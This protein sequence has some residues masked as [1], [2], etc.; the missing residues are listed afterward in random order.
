MGPAALAGGPRPILASVRVYDRVLYRAAAP[1]WRIGGI[2]DVAAQPTVR[3]MGL[4]ADVMADAHAFM[5]KPHGEHGAPCMLALLHT[6]RAGLGAYYRRLGYLAVPQSRLL[7]PAALFASPAPPPA[8]AAAVA[9]LN[10]VPF[11]ELSSLYNLVGCKAAGYRFRA[12]NR[13][14]PVGGDADR[15]A[16]AIARALAPVDPRAPGRSYPSAVPGWRG[17]PRGLLVRPPQ[18]RRAALR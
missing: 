3:G 6:S 9:P 10:E 8:L 2:G 1:C 18:R 15:A 7:L 4:A 13:L 16:G 5:A 11:D 17:P 14:A 12:Y